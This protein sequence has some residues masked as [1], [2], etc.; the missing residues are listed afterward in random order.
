M[1]K[2]YTGTATATGGRN[3]HVESPDKLVNFDFRFPKE[4]GGANDD[5]LNPELLS[6]ENDGRNVGQVCWSCFGQAK[7]AK[8]LLRK[9]FYLC[10]EFAG[11]L[12]TMKILVKETKKWMVRLLKK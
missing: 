6:C 11:R 12:N 9:L 7:R 5:Y 10:R 1:N 3:G 4:L 8:H 2:I